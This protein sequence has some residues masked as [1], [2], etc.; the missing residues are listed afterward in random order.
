[1]N[2]DQFTPEEQA[3]IERLQNAP[4]PRL[5][6]AAFD[7]IQQQMLLEMDVISAAPPAPKT[8]T[9]TPKIVVPVAFVITTLIVIIALT[10]GN[11]EAQAPSNT[12]TII[13]PTTAQ[14][15][16]V[17]AEATEA[18]STP[19]PEPTSTPTVEAEL[20]EAPVPVTATSTALPSL[21]SEPEAA[22]PLIVIEGPVTAIN[23]NSITI[24]DMN[25]QVDAASPIWADIQIG[26]TVRVEGDADTDGNLIIVAVNIT[27][28]ET[29]VILVD[30]APVVGL[31]AGCKLT[32]F[33][34]GNIRCKGS[35]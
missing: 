28:I 5:R 12:P 13:N 2:N 9:L 17:T 8:M 25:I 16:E 11:D 34:N 20:T 31:P 18:L 24:F 19:V 4:Q 7:R 22:A 14:D 21:T 33:G 15:I 32:G 26:D 1:M 23:A 29:D 10:L 35:D 30:G 3:L 6:Q 27:V